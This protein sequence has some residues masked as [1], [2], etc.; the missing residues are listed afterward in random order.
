MY[1]D[2][3]KPLY[4]AEAT[5]RFPNEV[6]LR[7]QRPSPQGTTLTDLTAESGSS[8]APTPL[9]KFAINLPSDPKEVSVLAVESSLS[10]RTDVTIGRDLQ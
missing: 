5:T 1:K 10:R 2:L 4:D 6:A 3:D 9:Y 7:F 8:A